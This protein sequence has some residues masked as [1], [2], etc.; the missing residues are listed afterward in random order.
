MKT[1]RVITLLILAAIVLATSVCIAQDPVPASE[2]QL[3]LK[4][5]TTALVEGPTEQSRLDAAA[6]LLGRPDKS[7]RDVLLK[8]LSTKDNLLGQTAICRTLIKK[9]T[10][11]RGILNRSDFLEPLMA[12]LVGDSDNM[13]ALAGETLLIFD[14]AEV[15]SKLVTLAMS[16]ELPGRVRLNVVGALK[17]WPDKE[18]IS[19]LIVLV[20]DPDK[21]VASA[22]EKALRDA[23]GIPDDTDRQMLKGIVRGL[24]FKTP[25]EIIRDLMVVQRERSAAQEEQMR[26]LALDRDLWREMYLA[27]LDRTYAGADDTGKAAVLTGKLASKLSAERIWAL[28]KL[29]TFSGAIEGKMRLAVLALISDPEIPVRLAAA[30]TLSKNSAIDPAQKLLAQLRVEKDAQTALAIFDALGQAC[31]YAFS[32]GS[33]IKLS[34]DIRDETLVFAAAYVNNDDGQ[35][36]LKGADVIRKML[37][38]N[39]LPEEQSTKYLQLIKSR[40]EKT[41][42]DKDPARARLLGVMARLCDKPGLK[43]L[44]GELFHDVFAVAVDSPKDNAL[45]EAAVQGLINIDKPAAFELLKQ[46]KLSDDPSA[47]VRRMVVILAGQLGTVED[48]QWLAVK[49]DSNGDS[50]VAWQSIVSILNRNNST[51]VLARAMQ[52]EDSPRRVQLLTIAEAKAA[53]EKNPVILL[54]CRRA[55]LDS[56][57][58]A[59]DVSMAA[60]VIAKRLTELKDLSSSDPLVVRLDTWLALSTTAPDKKN[61][62]LKALEQIKIPEGVEAAKWQ[63]K[64]KNWLSKYAVELPPAEKPVNDPA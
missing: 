9:R 61:N 22:A 29:S 19:V 43:A 55:L 54:Q 40:Y 24:Q 63:L 27:T 2:D 13:A 62:L 41:V 39:G 12:I 20:D 57:L 37:D 48:F 49:A 44:A 36:A 30:K 58:N 16:R 6:V 45:R 60:Q 5:I 15:S 46:K 26:S 10:R 56:Y 7:S 14:F 50:Q 51:V 25:I 47:A 31:F 11:S 8:V 35:T 53:A 64:L 38:L 34:R 17:L 28:E 52:T 21:Q 18:A 59:T 32:P 4:V 42:L 33:P 3:Q 1:H 23:F